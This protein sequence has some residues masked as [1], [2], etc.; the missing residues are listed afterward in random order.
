VF[1]PWYGWSGRTEPADNCCMN[2][3]TY[4]RGGGRFA[5]T[6]RGRSAL[7]LEDDAISIGPSRMAWT[8]SE[9]VIDVEERGAAFR[10]GRLKGRVTLRPD[11]IT[12]V[13]VPLTPDGTHVWR[14][15]SPSSRIEVDLGD[16]FRWSGHGY[17]DSNFGTRSLEDDFRLWTWG[18][19][20]TEAGATVFYDAERRDGTHLEA[21][22]AFENGTAREIEAPPRTPFARS[23]WQ[24]RRET[25][26]D[27]GFLPRQVMSMLDAPFYSR[28]TVRTRIH[29]HETTGVH[30]ALDLDR[31]RSPLMKP[32]VAVRV[33]RRARWP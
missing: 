23:R 15:F 33:P 29:G 9:L 5:M 31:F 8:G 20:P 11:A 14:P 13:E 25:R 32:L 19:F 10:F 7:R 2:V 30:E 17:F 28:A 18:R 26:A 22:I 1:S 24:V 27:R 3:A 4:G 6:D 16:G 21:A 12:S